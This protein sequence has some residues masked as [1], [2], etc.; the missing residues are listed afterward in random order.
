MSI[1][2][3]TVRDFTPNFGQWTPIGNISSVVQTGNVF[4][5]ALQGGRTLQLSFL[6]STCFRVRFNPL[7]STNYAIESSIAVVN[8]NLGTVSLTIL[9]NDSQALVVDTGTI[10]VRVDLQPYRVRVFR[11]G[12][13]ISAD[14]P[15]YNLVYIPGERV[16]ANFKSRQ[17]SA[18]PLRFRRKGR[19]ATGEDSVHHDPVQF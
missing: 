15:A 12:Q 8:R 16:I 7:P 13:L 1:P 17:N 3:V 11:N 6:S 4:T 14:E 10:V 2:F 5:L 19:I 9:Q 18:A